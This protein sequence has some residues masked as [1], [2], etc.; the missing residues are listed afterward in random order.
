[1]DDRFFTSSG[2]P[3]PFRVPDGFFEEQ[4]ERIKDR[5][6]GYEEHAVQ[7]SA[8]QYPF[9]RVALSLAAA[10]AIILLMISVFRAPQS[11]Q[12]EFLPDLTLDHL[13][14]DSP[15]FVLSF[16]ESELIEILFS[17]EDYSI[18]DDLEELPGLDSGINEEDLIDY[19]L[20]S[21]SS[22]ELIYN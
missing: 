3:N 19:L 17:M 18:R 22:E 6:A 1:M 21:E 4:Q 13:L 12:Q 7:D 15:D 10:A 16:E 20:D 2:K 5:V 9:G 14:Q 11:N 8:K